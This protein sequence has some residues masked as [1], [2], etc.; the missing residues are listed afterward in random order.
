MRTYPSAAALAAGLLVGVI[1]SISWPA[2]ATR[3]SAGTYSLPGGNPVVSG[4]TISSTWANNTLADISVELTN[5]LDRQGRGAML[6]PLQVVQGTAGAPGLTF[7]GDPDTGLYRAGANDVRMQVDGAQ[8]LQFTAAGTFTPGTATT[9]T[10]SVTGTSAFTG[11]TAFASPA[12]FNAGGGAASLRPGSADHT[13]LEYY[14]DSDAPTVRSGYS[15]Y[16]GAGTSDF[17][18]VNLMTAGNI[19]LVTPGRVLA[20]APVQVLSANPSSATAFANTLTPKNIVKAWARVDASGGGSTTATVID[21]FN[22][23]GANSAGTSL[24]VNMASSFA[25]TSYAVLVTP[26]T[27]VLACSGV[28]SSTTQVLVSCRDISGASVPFPF[29]NFQSG[30]SRSIS[31][32]V[33]GAQ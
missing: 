26:S 8:S 13:Y 7:V 20:E 10:L 12:A 14:A 30:A 25:N 28:F 1:V 33:L 32:A 31:V 27:S 17:A 9:G 4:T 3:N 18:V 6:A 5:S 19:R 11:T 16:G 22:V 29:H 24:L 23:T 2:E 21:G 15:G